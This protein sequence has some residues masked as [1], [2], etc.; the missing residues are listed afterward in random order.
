[1]E[2]TR[3]FHLEL[4]GICNGFCLRLDNIRES[5]IKLQPVFD[6]IKLII[7]NILKY[8]YY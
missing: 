2:Q 4:E 1:M 6:T 8:L 5:V 3:I 7:I